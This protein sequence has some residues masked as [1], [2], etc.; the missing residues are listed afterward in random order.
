MRAE[1]YY[2][3]IMEKREE[4]V[5]ILYDKMQDSTPKN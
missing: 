2:N 5:Q 4:N 1:L 3:R